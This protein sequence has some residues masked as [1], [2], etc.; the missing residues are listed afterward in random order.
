M[1]AILLFAFGPW[2]FQEPTKKVTVFQ[3]REY[4]TPDVPLGSFNAKDISVGELLREI[5]KD[6]RIN[7]AV[8]QSVTTRVTLQLHQ[9]SLNALLD[10]L[11]NAYDLRVETLGG[12]LHI[13]PPLPAQPE[14]PVNQVIYDAG[15]DTLAFNLTAMKVDALARTLTELS[16]RNVLLRDLDTQKTVKGFQAPLP[17]VKGLRL[18]LSSNGLL[19]EE[20]EGVFFI[21]VEQPLRGRPVPATGG[22]ETQPTKAPLTGVRYSEGRYS[23]SYLDSPL[24][25]IVAEVAAVGEVSLVVQGELE[26]NLSIHVEDVPIAMLFRLLF[27][28]TEYSFV[29]QDRVFVIGNRETTTLQDYRLIKL[30][31]LNAEMVQQTLPQTVVG[32]STI[33]IVKELN[34]LLLNGESAKLV[35]LENMIQQMDQPIPQVL[36]EVMVVDFNYTEDQELGVSVTNGDNKIFPELDVGL[37]ANRDAGGNFR[38]TRLPSNFEV[39]I[40]A[41]ESQEKA[42]IIS[43]PHVAALNG[44]EASIKIGSKQFYRVEQEELVGDQTP[45]LRTSEQIQD[46]EANIFLKITPWVSGSGE[47]TTVIEPTFT[48]F[49]GAIV[50]NIPPPISTRELKSTVRLKDGET[51]ILG[52]LIEKFD[53]VNHQ[54]VPFFSRIPLLGHL[55]RNRQTNRR[56]SELVIYIT[57]HI[58][59]GDE[60]S[61]EIIDDRQGLEYQ[62]DVKRQKKGIKGKVPGKVP[63]YKRWRKKNREIQL[64]EEPELDAVEKKEP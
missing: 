63:W 57:P 43:K 2:F 58:Y 45:R 60:G 51:I 47:V 7:L 33:T 10:L 59:Y 35:E 4:V 48:T 5:A 38:I 14:A 30:E 32:E 22:T 52:G 46:I 44:H 54:G 31:H 37:E 61:V 3:P 28:G 34:S 53:T 27:S 20:E 24:K 49:L 36:I 23:L 56:K 16:G 29:V 1:T 39:K 19:L 41:L 17:L 13:K 21:T 15:D 8:D 64:P 42:R 11:V 25:T 55:F 6:K 12:I 40:R 9:T 18:L 26:G 62:L 50:D